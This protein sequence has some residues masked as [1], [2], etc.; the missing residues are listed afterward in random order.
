MPNPRI[1]EEYELTTELCSY[2][3]N[4]LAT[5]A[6]KNGK[7][8]CSIFFNSCPSYRERM[9]K[10]IKESWKPRNID[11]SKVVRSRRLSDELKWANVLFDDLPMTRKRKQILTEQNN[12]CLCGINTWND[13]PLPLELDHV[14]GNHDNRSRDN[15]RFLCPNCHAQTPTWR[16]Q[17]HLLP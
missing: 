4:T 13:K 10:R 16:K 17:K 2:G 15:L 11:Y 12:R 6:Y 8:C 5:V 9:T 7:F 3:C 14:D 1:L